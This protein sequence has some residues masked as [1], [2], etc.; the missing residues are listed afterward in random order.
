MFSRNLTGRDPGA[1]K[2]SPPDFLQ[3][4]KRLVF[5]RNDE[6]WHLWKFPLKAEMCQP[7]SSVS[8]REKP[9]R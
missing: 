7:M 9:N 4:T 6:A 1:P 5:P 2:K 8:A 3:L